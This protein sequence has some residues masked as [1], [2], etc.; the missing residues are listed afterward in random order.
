MARPEHLSDLVRLLEDLFDVEELRRFAV[1]TPDCGDLEA[2]IPGAVATPAAVA[3]AI[4]KGLDSRGLIDGDFFFALA[5]S[6]HS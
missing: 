5:E 6:S 4:V 2:H 3:F 1:T